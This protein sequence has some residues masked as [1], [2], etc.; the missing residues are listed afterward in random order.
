MSF[1]IL[2]HV[3]RIRK[4]GC[5]IRNAMIWMFDLTLL[6][7]LKM[8]FVRVVLLMLASQRIESFVGNWLWA[9]DQN[10]EQ[11]PPISDEFEVPTKRGATPSAIEWMILAWVS[12]K[13]I[14]VSGS[15]YHVVFFPI[16]SF[17]F[18]ME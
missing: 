12:G 1:S 9:T 10:V 8:D 4:I 7:T 3:L 11:N 13:L 17:R 15:I 6:T 5:N 16:F 2:F 18:D 14:Y